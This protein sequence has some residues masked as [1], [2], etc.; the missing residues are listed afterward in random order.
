[1][2]I[3]IF[4]HYATPP[5]VA[6]GTRHYDL[7]RELVRRGHQVTIFA[8]G[9]S[10]KN[11]KN[12]KIEVND[13]WKSEDV[14]GIRFVWLKT[15]PYRNNDWRRVVNMASY[16]LR[17]WWEGR[18]LT[19]RVPDAASP[20]V[21]IGSSV[22]LLAVLAAYRVARFHNAAFV[23]EVRDLWPQ[24]IVD[25]GQLSGG[26][27]LTKALQALERFLYR[28]AERII[29]LLPRAR[30]YIEAQGITPDK[31]VWVPNGVSLSSFDEIPDQR[32]DSG[33]FRMMY[34]GAHGAAN[35]LSVVLHA[36]RIVQEKKVNI[37]FLL[38]GDGPEKPALHELKDEL[39]LENLDL[40]DP[41]HK[42]DVPKTLALADGFIFHLR[43]TEIF[44][45]GLSPNKLFDYMAAGRPILYCA[46]SSI[47]AVQAAGCGLAV[48]PENPQALADA[49]IELYQMSEEERAAMGQRGRTYVEQHHAIPVLADRLVQCL[50]EVTEAE[51]E[52]PS[53]D[54]SQ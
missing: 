26:H 22:H 49:V 43:E 1:M 5:D 53:D 37:E 8:S 11:R 21:V 10:H 51:L 39:E 32:R 27:P 3:W 13:S 41:V 50:E 18:R 35:A 52:F 54:R 20:D 30:E 46:E 47:N 2:N 19:K 4:N 25:M 45:Y 36:A 42:G 44:R 6:G 7:G 29:T 28:R 17:A 38:V 40:C 14:D 12:V 16:M 9:F 48:S 15:Y 23:M 33:S 24:T 34:L 31:V